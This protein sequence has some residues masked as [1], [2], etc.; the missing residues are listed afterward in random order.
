M[1]SKNVVFSKEGMRVGV[2]EVRGEREVD[3]TQRFVLLVVVSMG[4]FWGGGF[5]L[6]RVGANMCL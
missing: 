3:G 6:K 4:V 5:L 2:K 1:E